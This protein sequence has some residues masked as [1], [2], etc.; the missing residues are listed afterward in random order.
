MNAPVSTCMRAALAAALATAL[1]AAPAPALAG[2]GPGEVNEELIVN[3]EAFLA[4]HPDLKW[5]SEATR[6]FKRGQYRTAAT[7]LQRAARYADKPSQAMYAEM[8][9]EGQGVPR[10]RALAYAWMDLAAER[11]YIPF[12]IKREHYWNAL[13]AAERERAIARG[14]AVYAEYGDAVA[15]PRHA[16]VLERVGSRGATGSRLSGVG[17]LQIVLPDPTGNWN[18]ATPRGT[19]SGDQY[20][21]DRYWDPDEYWAWQDRLWRNTSPDQVRGLLPVEENGHATR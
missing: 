18:L 6:A 14:E 8:L 19:V 1:C 2:P 7:Y 17:R 10:D 5:R 20:Y 9:W 21:R 4:A 12:L 11:G 13:D 3:T 15:K 16:E